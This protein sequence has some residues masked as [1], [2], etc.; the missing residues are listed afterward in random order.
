[1]NS[2]EDGECALTCSDWGK[3]VILKCKHLQIARNV[4]YVKRITRL[5]IELT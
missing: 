1:M 2:Q 4:G 3:S 5:K